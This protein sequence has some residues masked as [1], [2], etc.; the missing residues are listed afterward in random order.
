[1]LSRRKLLGTLAAA[2]LLVHAGLRAQPARR[3]G[4]A[5]ILVRDN[6]VWTQV[7]FGEQGPYAFVIDTGTFANLIRDDLAR[8]LHFPALGQLN[9]RGVGG[10]DTMIRY[11]ADGVHLGMVDVGT[12]VF[13]GYGRDLNIHREASGALAAN[14]LTFAD[15][16]LDF[17]AGEWR[18]YPDGRGERPGYEMLD[19]QIRRAEPGRGASPL[20]VTIC[21]GDQSYRLQVDTGAPGQIDLWGRGTRRSALWND[22]GPYVPSRFYGIGGAGPRTR[23]VRVPEVRIGSIRFERALVTLAD[24]DV[25]ESHDSDGL[26][27][28]QLLERMNLSTDVRAGKLWAK[29]NALPQRPERYGLSGLWVDARGDKLVVTQ[30]SPHS[31]AAEAGMR[32]G[33]EIRGVPLDQ[34]VRQLARAPGT[35]VDVTYWRDGQLHDTHL[36]LR[37]FL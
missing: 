3:V 23:I 36:T 30:L 11:R 2:P 37:P 9:I 19:S 18:I 26:I 25:A 31:P 16:D 32:V 10:V 1:M 27:G 20:F 24:P 15:A 22:S 21:I 5:R 28:L 12:L 14:V 33:D 34:W 35:V 13:A 6:R 4:G 29:R 8:Q 7:R 17:E